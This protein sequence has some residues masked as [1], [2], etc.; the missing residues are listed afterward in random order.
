MADNIFLNVTHNFSQAQKSWSSLGTTVKKTSTNFNGANTNLNKMQGSLRRLNTDA[1]RSVT[2]FGNLGK[3]VNNVNFAAA[4]A[5]V[6]YLAKAVA[7]FVQASMDS[8]EVV[9]MFNVAMG[10]LAVETNK[11][12]VEISNIT[13][14][15]LTNLQEAT[16]TFNN[17]A[18]SMGLANETAQ[19]LSLNAV[20]I[21][22]DLSS[23]F[24]IPFEQVLADLRSGLIG[25]TETVYKYGVDLTEASLKQE[26]LRLGID[27]SVRSMT[28][29]EKMF[30][31]MSKIMQSSSL[32]AG[33]F[34]RTIEQPANQIRLLGENVT[35][36]A[37][38]FGSI[39]IPILSKVIPYVRAIVMVLTELFSIIASLFGYSAPEIKNTSNSVGGLSGELD[40]ASDSAGTLKK[41]LKD[42]AAPFDELNA[43]N[44]DTSSGSGS[45]GVGGI[46]SE[47]FGQL[48][49]YDSM[50]GNVKQKAN[51]IRDSI[52]EWLGFTKQVNEETGKITWVL[53]ET[54]GVINDVKK[55]LK[56]TTDAFKRLF[57]AMEPLQDFA[58]DSLKG[59]YDN[60]LKP[61]ASY[62]FSDFLP[63]LVDVLTSFV[64][65]IDYER[66]T[67]GLNGVWTELEPLLETLGDL[68]LWLL[69]EILLPI[70]TAVANHGLPIFLELLGS[71]LGVVNA[72]IEL[73]KPLLSWLW[74]NFLKPIAS[75]TGGIIIQ[76]LEGIS[77]LLQAIASGAEL[78]LE[79]VS[80]LFK[81]ETWVEFGQNIKDGVSNKWNEFVDWWKNT[82]IPNWWNNNVAPWFTKDKWLTTAQSIKDGISEKWNEFVDWWNNTAIVTW[83][84]ENVSPWFTKEKWVDLLVGMKDGFVQGWKNAVNGAIEILN[85]LI[86]WINEHLVFDFD[87]LTVAGKEIIP[88]FSFVLFQIPEITPLARGGSLEAGSIFQAGEAGA[89]LIGSYNN[90]TTVMPL[91]NSGFVEAMYDAVYSAVSAAQESGGG[92]V[93]ENVLTIDGDVI[94]K[95]QKKVESRKGITFG[96]PAFAR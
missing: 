40:D 63:G 32:A 73:V 48:A 79:A 19:T 7:R 34:A 38:S 27:K 2:T 47:L 26:A 18:R 11:T 55:L 3:A 84:N 75:W 56:P 5:K 24:N 89:E 44:I 54:E 62:T 78:L 80:K 23:L 4:A 81:K 76:V 14:L 96:S 90:K 15:D 88:A 25:Q 64:S 59:F 77:T 46:D 82:G 35:T 50:L 13:G 41:E 39:F 71:A 49:E 93:I 91:E 53:S 20:Q 30:L 22:T 52:M 21:A 86:R 74:D 61:L 31:R 42:L 83:W 16:G 36:M 58:W 51:D 10:N 37:R 43:I 28:Q 66:I 94:Y 95:S 6:I 87:G 67:E 12:L 85:S 92:Q 69:N 70:A 8:I 9:N 17:L 45:A 68:L 60:F 57:D 72:A 29:G 33:D 1:N 65:S